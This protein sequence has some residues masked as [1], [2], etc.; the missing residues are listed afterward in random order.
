MKDQHYVFTVGLSNTS[1]LYQFDSSKS[2]LLAT[3]RPYVALF[4]TRPLSANNPISNCTVGTRFGSFVI[5][6]YDI[7][8]TLLKQVEYRD[9]LITGF[10]PS[11]PDLVLEFTYRP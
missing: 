7:A 4:L 8:G 1:E 3:D 2:K 5:R 9:V 6:Q 10:N 11:A